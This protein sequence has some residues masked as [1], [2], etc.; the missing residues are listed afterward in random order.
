MPI[1]R[2]RIGLKH[3]QKPIE[4]VWDARD[5]RDARDTEDLAI[6]SNKD[7][8]EEDLEAIIHCVC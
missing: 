2:A 3:F 7:N 1:C 8:W 5:A 4:K 6:T